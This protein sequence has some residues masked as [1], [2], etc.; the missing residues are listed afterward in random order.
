MEG[1]LVVTQVGVAC[2][3]SSTTTQAK[4]RW[5]YTRMENAPHVNLGHLSLVNTVPYTSL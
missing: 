4:G 1:W 5:G 2:D 3:D